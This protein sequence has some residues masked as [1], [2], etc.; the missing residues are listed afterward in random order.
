MKN[1]LHILII[2]ITVFFMVSCEKSDAIIETVIYCEQAYPTRSGETVQLSLNGVT[3]Y[4]EKINDDYIFQGDI[5]LQ[6][7]TKGAAYAEGLRWPD[8]TVYYTINSNLPN[9]NRVTEAIDEYESVT[10]LRFVERSKQNDYIEFVYDADGCSS[11]LGMIGGK[12]KIRIADWGSKGNVIHEIGHA[13]GLLHE[14]SK[15][16]RDSYLNIL[17]QNIISGAEHNFQE[18]VS[19]AP[20][21]IGFDWQ[22]IM[23]YPSLAFSKNGQP[24]ITKKNGETFSSQRKFLSS[25][26][27]KLI[28]VLYPAMPTVETASISDITKN[29]ASCGGHILDDG[30]YHVY[31]KGVCWDDSR[32]PRTTDNKTVNG[33]GSGSFTSMLTGLM[34]NT[35]YY[36]RAYATNAEG[37][38]YG[39]EKSFITNNEQIKTIVP[40]NTC[41]SA[42]IMEP[43]IT[44]NV[45]IDVGDYD[46]A[47]PIENHS[48]GNTN[49]RGFWL[50]FRTISDWGPDHDVKIFNVSNNFDPVFGIRNACTSPY[51]GHTPNYYGYVD[52]NG[53]GGN[54]T[55]DTNLPG[56][57]SGENLDDIMYVRIYHYIGSET[58]SI[59]FSIKVE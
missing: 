51:V 46:L 2:T 34:P 36:V 58:P 3:V 13:I 41:S 15:A 8:N 43:Y 14:H 24:T 49:V 31:A 53:K 29:S 1:Y 19:S 6:S 59:S 9:K 21:T 47:P 11:Y 54:E 52:K 35:K 20:N 50:A 45:S 32:N 4:C 23:L 27:I 22:S 18:F 40:S 28:K 42:P 10:N 17:D 30:G 33:T 39:Q 56:S 57:D 25:D 7:A 38:A 48:Y 55:S 5:L 12:Q 16:G 44:Y 37:T 26:D